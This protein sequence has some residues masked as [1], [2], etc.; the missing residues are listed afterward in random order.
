MLTRL[1][2]CLPLPSR[3]AALLAQGDMKLRSAG[4]GGGTGAGSKGAV[5]G[6]KEQQHRVSSQRGS[7]WREWL[8]G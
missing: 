7:A 3:Y 2:A 6:A 5:S 8:P 1:H 4:M